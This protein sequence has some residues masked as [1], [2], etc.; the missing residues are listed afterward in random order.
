MYMYLYVCI[1]IYA[2]INLSLSLS[3]YIYI[4]IHT[5][6][7][8][9]GVRAARPL[10]LGARLLAV[11]AAARSAPRCVRKSVLTGISNEICVHGLKSRPHE[12]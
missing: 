3:L 6:I 4:Y 12:E 8:R 1:Y 11:S 10:P 9:A 7:Q 2:Y 5:Y